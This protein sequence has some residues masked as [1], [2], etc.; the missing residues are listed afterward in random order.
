MKYLIH[1]TAQTKTKIENVSQ[2]AKYCI[3]SGCTNI[4]FDSAVF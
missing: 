1:G 3:V 2:I 4:V